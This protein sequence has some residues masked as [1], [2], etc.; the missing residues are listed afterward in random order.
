MFS[1]FYYR[2]KKQFWFILFLV[3]ELGAV[4]KYFHAPLWDVL[5]QAVTGLICLGIFF[6]IKFREKNK[7]T[8]R[9]EE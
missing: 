7:D 2:Y 8:K 5:L 9:E 1:A 4:S 3:M 6:S